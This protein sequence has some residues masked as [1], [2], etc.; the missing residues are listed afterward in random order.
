[1][2]TRISVLVISLFI[3]TCSSHAFG[4]QTIEGVESITFD[5]LQHLYE[6]VIFDHQTHSD[7]YGCSR[8]HHHT[9][10]EPS[11]QKRC[12]RCHNTS[13]PSEDVACSSCHKI[14][15]ESLSLQDLEVYHIDTPGLKGALHLQCLGCHRSEEGPTDC[16]D[17]HDFTSAGRKRF[18]VDK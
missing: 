13:Q 9:T 8:C 1:M 15:K 11:E 5:Y 4:V 12:L 10:G 18:A 2:K 17:C 16:V 7:M 3:L 6:P 14:A